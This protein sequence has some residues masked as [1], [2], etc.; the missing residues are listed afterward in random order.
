LKVFASGSNAPGSTRE[1]FPGL[2]RANQAPDFR[3]LARTASTSCWA[4]RFSLVF[5]A[6]HSICQ[7]CRRR[8]SRRSSR[9]RPGF[10]TWGSKSDPDLTEVLIQDFEGADGLPLLAFTLERLITD[11]GA[12]GRIERREYIDEMKGVGGAIRTAIETAFAIAKEIPGLPRSRAELDA[13]A[14]RTFVP[15]L[16]RIDDA[17]AAPKRR[18]ALRRQ[19]PQEALPLIDCLT[20]EVSHEARSASLARTRRLDRGAA[21]G[22][23]PAMCEMAS[24][25]SPCT[26][27]S[28]AGSA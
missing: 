11:D 27:H 20:V 22:A 23:Q 17:A 16:V 3:G 18:V 8:H 13:L 7:G 12:D 4:T 25:R 15:G 6:S 28:D 9:A 10:A 14:K 24:S 1:P 19:L 5:L 2:R 21:C 26:V